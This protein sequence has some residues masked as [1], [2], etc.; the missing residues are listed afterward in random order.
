[1]AKRITVTETNE[2]SAGL[3]EA[4]AQL[5]LAREGARPVPGLKAV[6]AKKPVALPGADGCKLADHD[7]SRP[8]PALVQRPL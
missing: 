8:V 7:Q 2:P 3:A 1:M 6:D 4:F 5:L